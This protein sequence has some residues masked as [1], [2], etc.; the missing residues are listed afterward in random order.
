MAIN[1]TPPSPIAINSLC[2]AEM[3]EGIELPNGWKVVAKVARLPTSTGGRFSVPYHVEKVEGGKTRRAF[4]KAL[5]FR[6]I[7]TAPDF[8][9]AAQQHTAAFNFERETL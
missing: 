7:A 5:N 9:K 6:L 1:P 2:E 3:L 4:L 8:A